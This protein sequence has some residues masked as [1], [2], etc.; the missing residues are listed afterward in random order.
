MK[1][2][3]DVSLKALWEITTPPKV[4]LFWGIVLGVIN[5]G[6]SLIIPLIL[7]EQ[8][9]QLSKGFSYELL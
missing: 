1:K 3:T 8:I 6:C 7:K 9:E 2:E 5:S 4:K